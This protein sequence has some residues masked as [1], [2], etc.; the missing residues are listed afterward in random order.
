MAV[1]LTKLKIKLQ[2]ILNK[3]IDLIMAEMPYLPRLGNTYTREQVVNW[4]NKV[5]G[6]LQDA[7]TKTE[8]QILQIRQTTYNQLSA[9]DKLIADKIIAGESYNLEQAT[10]DAHYDR[11]VAIVLIQF[12]TTE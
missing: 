1:N 7:S 5:A 8:A 9:S 11:L 3:D 2:A 4:L 10:T 6:V 12:I